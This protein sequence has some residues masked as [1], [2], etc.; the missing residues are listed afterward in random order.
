[1]KI[2]RQKVERGGSAAWVMPELLKTKRWLL[3]GLLSNHAETGL[4]MDTF[5]PDIQFTEHPFDEPMTFL[6]TWTDDPMF[7][8]DGSTPFF[9]S[10]IVP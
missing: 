9:A 10:P 1:M 6:W 4:E 3:C 2:R 7:S 5:N 8:S